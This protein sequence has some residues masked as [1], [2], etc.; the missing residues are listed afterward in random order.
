M[1]LDMPIADDQGP[2]ADV[3]ADR[4]VRNPLDTAIETELSDCVMRCIQT[5]T[6][7]EAYIVRA[8]FGLDTGATRTLEDIGQALQLSRERVRLVEHRE[9]CAALE[10]PCLPASTTPDRLPQR[11]DEV[12]VEEPLSTVSRGWLPADEKRR[13][14]GVGGATGLTPGAISPSFG[15]RAKAREPGFTWRHWITWALAIAVGRRLM[16]AQTARHGPTKHRVSLRKS[17]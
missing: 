15:K 10:W 6:P 11:L 5:F 2:L 17:R 9:R 1:S 14:S 13:A 3:F 7:R 12:V 8:G 4:A 16:V